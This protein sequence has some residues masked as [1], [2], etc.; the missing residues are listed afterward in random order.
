MRSRSKMYTVL[1]DKH[2]IYEKKKP[3]IYE[4]LWVK[5]KSWLKN[6]RSQGQ[7]QY[8]QSMPYGTGGINK[9]DCELPGSQSKEITAFKI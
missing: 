6:K 4:E 2:Q 1:L 9:L 7:G 5:V 3:Q 8:T